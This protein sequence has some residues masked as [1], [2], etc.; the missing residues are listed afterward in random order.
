MS[1]ETNTVSPSFDKESK[2]KFWMTHRSFQVSKHSTIQDVVDF[3]EEL[4]ISSR[5]VSHVSHLASPVN[6]KVKKTK[7]TCG[8]PPLSA[9]V[10]FDPLSSSWRTSQAS[11]L[12]NTWEEFSETWPRAG[13]LCDG[14]CWEEESL[15]SKLYVE[16]YGFLLGSIRSSMSE[17]VKKRI[18][19]AFLLKSQFGAQQHAVEY[20]ICKKTG[21]LPSEETLEWIMR[22]PGTWTELKPLEMDKFLNVWLMPLQSSLKE[23][24]SK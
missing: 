11:L 21:Q 13:I 9:F 18:S 6:P 16:D 20:L 2:M 3:I 19:N 8:L 10:R 4:Q 1:N 15:D 17:L 24:L 7:E 5:E 23:L 14:L 12:T 22:W